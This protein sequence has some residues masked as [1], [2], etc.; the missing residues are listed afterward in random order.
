MRTGAE[1]GNINQCRRRK[2]VGEKEEGKE[3]KRVK[4]LK[5]EEKRRVKRLKDKFLNISRKYK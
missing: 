2:L 3:K 4:N 1:R 5:K